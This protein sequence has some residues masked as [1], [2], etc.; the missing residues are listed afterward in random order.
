MSAVEHMAR[1]RASPVAFAREV[2]GVTPDDWQVEVLEAVVHSGKDRIA[3]KASKG[4]GKSTVL[5]LLLLTLSLNLVAVI[6]RARV[7]KKMRAG[8]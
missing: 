4:P 3:L 1:W 5:A 7:R 2:L 6:V 8:H